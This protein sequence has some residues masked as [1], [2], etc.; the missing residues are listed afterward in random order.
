MVQLV[1]NGET[2]TYAEMVK[3]LFKPMDGVGA[4]MMHACIG[5]AGESGEILTALG[6]KNLE[7]EFGDTEFYVEAAWQELSPDLRAAT[8]GKTRTHT[9][10]SFGDL[11]NE[12]HRISSELL[13]L[14]K[15][16]W[17]YGGSK[18]DRNA[19][20]ADAL[21][22]YE[23][24]LMAAYGFFSMGRENILYDNMLKLLGG[25]GVT[26]RYESGRYSDAEALARADKEGDITA[27]LA[28][29]FIGSNK[30]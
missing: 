1:K 25:D 19:Q 23:I 14:A 8:Y 27:R 7:E 21:M 10:I 17:V 11:N 30:A 5:I 26:G 9:L 24:T 2:I 4:R 16:V 22:E 29:N 15:K 18:G 13:D 6:R 12:L 28:R 20:I 3:R